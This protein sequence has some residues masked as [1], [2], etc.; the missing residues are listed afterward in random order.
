M[1][2]NSE[3]P[4]GAPQASASD[5]GQIYDLVVI[6]GGTA[7][8]VAAQGAAGLGAKVVMVEPNPPGG[9]CLWTGCVPSKRLLAAAKAAH[10]IRTADKHG[11]SAVEPKVDFAKVMSL[12][13]DVREHIS[14]HDSVET[15]QKAGVEVVAEYGRFVSDGTI[16]AG[17][18]KLRFRKAMI[19]TGARP[20]VPPIPG[21]R[22]SNPLTSENLWDLEALPERLAIVGGGAIGSELGQAFSRLGSS[23]VI[24][25]AEPRLLSNL[26]LNVS[27]LVA[28]RFADEG[29]SLKMGSKVT[30]VR[31]SGPEGTAEYQIATDDG[32]LTDVDRIL[33]ATGRRPNTSDLDLDNVGVTVGA[34]GHVDVNENLQTSNSHIYAGGDVVGRMPFTH[35]A[36]YHGGLVVSNALFK[37]RRQTNYD[38]IP[39]A[40]FTDPEIASVGRTT[41]PGLT[42]NSF[43]YDQLD[44]SVTSGDP[45]GFADLFTDSKGRL[46]GATVAGEAAGEA[47]NE[48][49]ARVKSGDKL[50]EIG[51]MIRPYPTFGEGPARAALEELRAKYFTPRTKR[52]VGPVLSAMRRF[53]RP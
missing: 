53:D 48:M 5:D 36:A 6:G 26:A 31:R 15:L 52:F 46:V 44:R 17:D 20:T 24:F 34:G 38:I 14:H 39:F 22:E 28:S 50:G 10:E 2:Q 32:D 37:L 41:G 40:I 47:I 51:L 33:V 4:A 8:L 49:T 19:A 27:E 7:G 29:I 3:Q 9:D 35:T 42:K 18:R 12:V 43:S 23:V 11:I 45:V 16:E 30:A 21:L 13:D 25:E 1:A